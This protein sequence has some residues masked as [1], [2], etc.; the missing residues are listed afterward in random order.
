[1]AEGLAAIGLAGN[2]VQFVSFAFVLVS[3]AKELHH[4]ASGAL[5]EN[6]DLTIISRDIRFLSSN[7]AVTG[8][9]SQQLSAIAHRC[10]TVAEELQ[11]A[12]AQLL[13]KQHALGSG[14]V[15]TKWRSFRTALKCV[16]KKADIEEMKR[17]LESLRDQVT[18]HMVSDTR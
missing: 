17:R 5:E 15:S 18:M 12:I 10:D 7:I 8:G 9:S 6:V 14:N 16:W 2:I 13:P 4:S 11:L 1:M 3:K